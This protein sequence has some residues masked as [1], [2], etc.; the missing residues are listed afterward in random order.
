MNPRSLKFRLVALYAGMMA[1]VFVAAAAASYMAFGS[2]MTR[3][4]RESQFRRARQ[5][6]QSLLSHGKGLKAQDVREDIEAHFDPSGNS[7]F[8]RVSR[9]DGAVLYLAAPPKDGSF[10]PAALPPPIWPDRLESWQ[11]VALPEGRAMIISS[12]HFE[13]PGGER[14]MVEA[15]APLD[16]AQ[17][18]LRQWLVFLAAV[19]PVVI[20]FGV[21]GGYWL[22]TRSLRP[23]QA[24]ASAAELITSRNLNERLPVSRTGDELERLSISLNRM[25]ER[26]DESFQQSRRFVADASHELRTPLTVL[27]GELEGIV[28]Q[29]DL[30]PAARD[31]AASLLEEVERLA[32]IVEGLFSLSRLDAGESHRETTVFDLAQLASTTVDQMALL[33]EDKKIRLECDAPEA[34]MVVGDRGRLKQVVVNLLDNA[35]KYTPEG[36]AVLLTV[37]EESNETVLTV[38]DNGIGIPEASLPHLFER[39]YRVDKGRSRDNGGAGLGLAIVKSIVAAH[40]GSVSV[41]SAPSKGSRFRIQLPRHRG[42]T[43]NQHESKS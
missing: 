31:S 5:M 34:V 38:S 23:V 37:R 28:G 43:E 22:V 24:M 35:I 30:P 16:Q 27:R 1:A 13:T 25:I 4:V 3:S 18:A 9:S 42:P 40:G 11:R 20:L 7:R 29:T 41:E 10:D 15:G 39:F 26:L 6:V 19:A 12:H 2:Y 36:G 21:G 14:F 32:N 8:V 17:A 33:A